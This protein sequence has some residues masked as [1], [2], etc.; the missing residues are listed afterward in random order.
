MSGKLPWF[1]CFPRDCLTDP[2]VKRLS[3]ASKGVWYTA[4]FSMWLENTYKLVGVPE[5]LRRVCECSNQ[6]MCTAILELVKTNTAEVS[7]ID[8]NGSKSDPK[9]IFGLDAKVMQNFDANLMQNITFEIVCRKIR[10]ALSLSEIRSNAALT[11]WGKDDAKL[12]QKS[13]AKGSDLCTLISVSGT[14]VLSKINDYDNDLVLGQEGKKEAPKKSSKV[15]KKPTLEEVKLNGAKLGL[16]DSECERFLNYY[17]AN[18][19]RVGR[20]PM[21]SWNAAMVNWRS[22]WQERGGHTAPVTKPSPGSNGAPLWKKEQLLKEA[23]EKHPANRS[24]TF[25]NPQHS[26]AESQD[27]A[28]KRKQLKAIQDAMLG[29]KTP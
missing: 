25:F 20:N 10:T 28:A 24:S 13:D 2:G 23:L 7:I 16:P 8:E 12:M 19:W 21:K 1:K 14:S 3:T 6:E 29:E 11:R 17:E 15:F 4:W 9:A 5:D 18:G 22:H 27:Y 26:F